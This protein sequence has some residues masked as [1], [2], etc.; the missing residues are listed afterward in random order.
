MLTQIFKGNKMFNLTS[1]NDVK[2]KVADLASSIKSNVESV[3]NTVKSDV[4]K[5][6]RGAL[7]MIYTQTEET[8]AQAVGV[9]ESLKSLLNQYTSGSNVTEIKD[10]ILDKAG[11]LKSLVKDEASHAYEASRDRTVQTVRERPIASLAVVVG[12]GLLLG[13]FLGSKKHSK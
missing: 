7:D 13:Y 9:I 6:A 8:K 3:T 12:A 1:E 4:Q 11:Q 2:N 10:Q 5:D